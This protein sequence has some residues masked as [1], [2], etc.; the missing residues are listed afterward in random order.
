MVSFTARQ[1]QRAFSSFCEV[2]AI[3]AGLQ[4][5]GDAWYAKYEDCKKMA[6]EALALLQVY[7]A[8]FILHLLLKLSTSLCPTSLCNVLSSLAFGIQNM[9]SLPLV[10]ELYLSKAFY[11]CMLIYTLSPI[12]A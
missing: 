1:R 10:S 4:Y 5:K 6:D 2:F 12:S 3:D 8:N 9:V 11:Y 7:S